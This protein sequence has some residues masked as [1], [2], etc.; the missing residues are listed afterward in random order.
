M[1][2]LIVDDNAINLKLLRTILE[3]DGHEV[4]EALDGEQALQHLEKG[5][6]D[7]I[8]S[9]ILMPKVDG[10]RL[11]YEVRRDPRFQQ[12][13]F[14]FFTAT[15]TSPADEKLCMD[16]GADKYLRKPSPSAMILSS[17][18]EA[19]SATHKVPAITL[20]T[21]D[22]VR[23][24]SERLVSKLEE[25]N[26]ELQCKTQEL[27]ETHEQLS[28][29]LAHSPAV[30]YSIDLDVLT[31]SVSLVSDNIERLLG[32]PREGVDWEWWKESLHPEDR[33]IVLEKKY[34]DPQEGNRTL[35]YR[36]RHADG[37]YCWIE[38]SNRVVFDSQGKAIKLVGVWMDI[39]ERKRAAE[40]LKQTLDVLEQRV[41]E[42]T[43]ALAS[44][45]RA[46]Q[47]AK[48][49]AD[50]ANHSK[51]EFLSRMSH[52]LRTP[53]NS[54]L[55]F[56]QLLEMSSLDELQKESVSHIL[57]AGRHLLRLIDEVLEISRIEVGH[58]S[59]SLESVSLLEVLE[60]SVSLMLR[61][62]KEGGVSIELVQSPTHLVRADRLRLRQVLINLISN[63]IK[64]NVNGGKVTIR[65]T[66]DLLSSLAIEIEDTGI[67]IPDAMIQRLFTPFDRLGA[68][69]TN[70][71]GTGL[72]LTLSRSLVNAMGGSLTFTTQ[73]GVGSCFQIH[74]NRAD[75]K[76]SHEASGSSATWKSSFWP[77][78]KGR[79]LVI[80]DNAMNSRLLSQ[81]FKEWPQAELIVAAQGR[82]GIELALRET[83]D[84]IL[85]DLHLPDMHGREVLTEL[86]KHD[87]LRQV[88]VI[89][90][91]ADSSSEVV[92]SLMELGA[93]KFLTKPFVLD[94]LISTVAE[95][96]KFKQ[97]S[98]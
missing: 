50:T 66:E 78:V 67:G 90:V 15:Y 84:V 7:A 60:E 31:P 98:K 43:N 79:I 73:E 80:E 9:D 51:S 36:I 11:C 34:M 96:I 71:E 28:N 86:Q 10:Y 68:T 94:E 17:L 23:E 25:K 53:M 20:T 87:K 85:L 72:G 49:V 5:A 18:R 33:A 82:A 30:I 22:V 39:S 58:F 44:S 70:I 75:E 4:I 47:L 48:E 64:Y 14:I 35:E 3:S 74:L 2:I 95:A 57:K 59:I 97:G 55:G 92:K 83:P 19:M 62:A 40:Q 91:S 41:T 46:L 38:D 61:V 93:F 89:I 27:E 21:D 42:R 12:I 16:L 26:V 88:P 32:V 8:I 1:M 69:S 81:L 45:N 63:A 6:V 56:S 76:D 54:V 52:E 13:P 37:S 29:L 77:G 24:Y 65:V